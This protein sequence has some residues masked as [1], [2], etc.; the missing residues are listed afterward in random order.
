MKILPL[1]RS[2]TLRRDPKA[3]RNP[4][5]RVCKQTMN[6]ILI[7]SYKSE[8]TYLI[9]IPC[10]S[11]RSLKSNPKIEITNSSIL[12]KSHQ[13]PARQFEL[14]FI[15]F[16]HIYY[17]HKALIFFLLKLGPFSPLPFVLFYLFPNS[18]IGPHL[19]LYNKTFC[20]AL[21]LFPLSLTLFAHFHFCNLVIYE[22][23]PRRT[24]K[25][26]VSDQLLAS[27][28][29]LLFSTYPCLHFH[30]P[31]SLICQ[32]ITFYNENIHTEKKCLTTKEEHFLQ[33]LFFLFFVF[34][35]SFLLIFQ[36]LNLFFVALSLQL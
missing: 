5:P 36:H 34:S 9:S 27:H 23:E 18:Y 35:L 32:L 28:F 13:S 6:F 3:R 30:L 20:L 17:F 21:S 7:E 29:L 2:H 22:K 15:C 8:S 25:G 33:F 16:F 14:F 10:L 26:K 12:N 11:L 24:E 4:G 31:Y 1:R 19:F